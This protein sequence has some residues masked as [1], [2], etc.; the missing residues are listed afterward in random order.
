MGLLRVRV[1]CALALSLVVVVRGVVPYVVTPGVFRGFTCFSGPGRFGAK[2]RVVWIKGVAAVTNV[3]RLGV[4][5]TTRGPFPGGVSRVRSTFV[6][7]VN[8]VAVVG[9]MW[10]DGVFL[11]GQWFFFL[12]VCKCGLSTANRS[13][14]FSG[15]GVLSTRLWCPAVF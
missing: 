10:G 13:A 4:L 5:P 1:R 9:A 2:G 6:G 8:P 3:V 7:V 14:S 12:V 11:V 15:S